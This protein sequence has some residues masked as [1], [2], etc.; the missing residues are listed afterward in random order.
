MNKLHHK[1]LLERVTRGGI[2]QLWSPLTEKEC[3]A[4]QQGES[5]EYLGVKWNVVLVVRGSRY[6]AQITYNG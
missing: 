2:E 3:R 1:A 5:I 4:L 6:T